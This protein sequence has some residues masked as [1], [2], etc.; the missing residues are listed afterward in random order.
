MELYNASVETVRKPGQL[1]DLD[2]SLPHGARAAVWVK[3]IH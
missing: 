1:L 2:E 3:M